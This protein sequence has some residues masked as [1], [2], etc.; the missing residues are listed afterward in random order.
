MKQ[1]N[2]IIISVFIF[3]II[4][5]YLVS[6]QKNQ[7]KEEV[8]TNDNEPQEDIKYYQINLSGEFL[9]TGTYL[10]PSDWTLK[11]LF[12]YGGVKQDGDLRGF[13]LTDLV[14]EKD[15]FVP[16]KSSETKDSSLININTADIYELMTLNGIGEVLAENIIEYRSEKLFT[17]IEEIK[18]VKGVGNYVYEKIKDCITI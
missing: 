2:I 7:K 11:M 12:E 16:K 9:R 5:F 4:V 3:V 13:V 8:I 14:E 1:Q 15:Y 18:S 6:C 17:S 10:I